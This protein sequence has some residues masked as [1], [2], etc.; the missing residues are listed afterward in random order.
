MFGK[1]AKT[2]KRVRAGKYVYSKIDTAA[3][4]KVVKVNKYGIAT[5]EQI[6]NLSSARAR[7]NFMG[8]PEN[9]FTHYLPVTELYN[10]YL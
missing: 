2:Y 9:D 6:D 4:F 3:F 5:I 8:K 10:N 7:N 1:K